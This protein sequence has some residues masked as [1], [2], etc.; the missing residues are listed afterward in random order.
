MIGM[1]HSNL[2]IEIE[3]NVG[4]ENIVISKSE[5]LPMCIPIVDCKDVKDC[6]RHQADGT[7]NSNGLWLIRKLHLNHE[8]E[9][10][11]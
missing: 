11:E 2:V 10:E 8:W 9:K 4:Q 7:Q 1:L 6:R 5:V 3:Q